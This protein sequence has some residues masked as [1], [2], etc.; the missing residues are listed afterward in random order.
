MLASW[1]KIF[2]DSLSPARKLH[3]YIH[4]LIF[5]VIVLPVLIVI[6]FSYAQLVENLNQSVLTG[7]SALAHLA[8]SVVKERLDRLV[9]IG[10]SLAGR[11]RFIDNIRGKKWTEA[12]DF[13]KNALADFPE[14][15]HIFVTDGKGVLLAAV[16]E[17]DYLVGQNFMYR[18]WYSGAALTRRPYVSEVYQTRFKPLGNV[19][20]VSVP[21]DVKEDGFAALLVFLVR[22][23][24]FQEWGENF[25]FASG[26]FVYFVDK[27]G[28]I[29]SHPHYPPQGPIIDFSKVPVVREALLGRK[30]IAINYSAIDHEERIAAFERVPGYGWGVVAQQPAT[31]AFALRDK[32]V[33]SVSLVYSLIFLLSCF[34][35]YLTIHYI[36]Q[37]WVSEE[38]IRALN[39]RLKQQNISLAALNKELEAFSYSVSHDLRAPLRSIDGFSRILL[40]D[41][42]KKLDVEGQVYLQRIRAAADSM[43]QL[44][45][46]LLNLAR[47]TRAEI[48]REDVDLSELAE[49][50]A[51]GLRQSEPDRQVDMVI[52]PGLIARA[53]LRL[54]RVVMENLLSNAWKFT[55][56]HAHARIDVGRQA[57]DG[58]TVFFVRDD[59]AGFDMAYASKLFGAFQRLHSHS[60]FPGTGIGLATVQR[61]INRHEGVIWAE[62]AVERGA[63]FYFTLE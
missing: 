36:H 32:T 14:I 43:A 12:S 28:H 31:A 54:A 16:P 49:K 61:I 26:G 13:V 17:G 51:A 20:A 23:E 15:D 48:Q 50:A 6:F 41:H 39:E 3:R 42:S 35:A 10:I 60:E 33:R 34:L 63:T 18:D 11:P 5:I 40:E 57:K 52:A 9:G 4:A 30:G 37:R 22:L 19:V 45:E 55:A 44:I 38:K 25:R 47:V 59:G 2:F 53:D 29:V 8:A 27:N 7:R 21:V 46:D 62:G 58:R 1:R 56:K 24:H